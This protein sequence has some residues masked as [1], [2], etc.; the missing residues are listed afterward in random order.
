MDDVLVNFDG[1]RR[2]T[3][4]GLIADF[5]ATRQVIFFTCHESTAKA[6]RGAA[7]ACTAL[8]LDVER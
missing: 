4:S 6:L 7:G 1:G 8:S 2:W 3:A 5:A